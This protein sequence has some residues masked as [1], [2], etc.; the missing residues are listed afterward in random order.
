LPRGA[1]HHRHSWSRPRRHNPTTTLL[2]ALRAVP[3]HI[4]VIIDSSGSMNQHHLDQSVSDV[5][6]LRSIAGVDRLTVIS[7]DTEAFEVGVPRAGFS[8]ALVGGGGTSLGV[9]LDFASKLRRP[10]DLVVVIS[11]GLTDWP[12]HPPSGLAPVVGLIPEGGPVG[13]GWMTTVTRSLGTSTSDG[14]QDWQ[15]RSSSP[16]PS[17]Y[18]RSISIERPSR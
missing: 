16:G 4:A 5:A 7:C 1:G 11:D 10:A 12:R 8:V 17:R 2:P 3:I 13:P 15:Q 9:G 18:S 6:T 14:H